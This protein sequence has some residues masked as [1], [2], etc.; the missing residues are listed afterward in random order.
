MKIEGRLSEI[1]MGEKG[2]IEDKEP[3]HKDMVSDGLAKE[4]KGWVFR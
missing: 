3:R 1:S 4:A 2:G